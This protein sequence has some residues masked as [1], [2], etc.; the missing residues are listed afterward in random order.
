MKATDL[1]KQVAEGKSVHEVVN[2][3][4][5]ETVAIKESSAG[6]ERVDMSPDQVADKF[7]EIIGRVAQSFPYID[8][9]WIARIEAD[10]RAG[11]DP[12]MLAQMA[13]VNRDQYAAA[14][15]KID[16][17]GDANTWQA[18]LQALSAVP[19]NVVPGAA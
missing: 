17:G 14:G 19:T 9:D 1:I 15:F 6:P 18:V 10:L 11:H 12:A 16:A 2:A 13:Q 4:I 5:N 7:A 3:A 8:S